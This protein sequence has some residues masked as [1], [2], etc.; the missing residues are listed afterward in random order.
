[1]SKLLKVLAEL[2]IETR[3]QWMRELVSNFKL[4]DSNLWKY[5]GYKSLDSYQEDSIEK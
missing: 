4:S 3:K 1:M 5:Y 2:V